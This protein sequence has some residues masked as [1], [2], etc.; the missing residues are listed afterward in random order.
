MKLGLQVQFSL[1][2]TPLHAGSVRFH[3][4]FHRVVVQLGV[5]MYHIQ[6]RKSSS[7]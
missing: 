6:A 7:R 3:G 2:C 1:H 4:C 5:E